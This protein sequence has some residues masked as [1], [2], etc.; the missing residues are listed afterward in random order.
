[1]RLFLSLIPGLIV[2]IAGALMFRFP[3]KTINHFYGYR[4]PASMHSQAAWDFA[5]QYAALQLVMA[6]F[7][8]LLVSSALVVVGLE[9]ELVI[10]ILPVLGGAAWTNGRTEVGDSATL[11]CERSAESR[12]MNV[13]PICDCARGEQRL[14]RTV[15]RPSVLSFHGNAS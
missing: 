7:A 14:C 3:P 11:R 5:N 1:M 4:T 2:T 15:R 10:T 12:R 13:K 9:N 8:M 6:G